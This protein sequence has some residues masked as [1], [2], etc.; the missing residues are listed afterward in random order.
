VTAWTTAPTKVAA[1]TASATLAVRRLLVST[2]RLSAKAGLGT[3]GRSRRAEGWA[4]PC[5]DALAGRPWGSMATDGVASAKPNV[6]QVSVVTVDDQPHFRSAAHDVIDA[7]PGFKAVGEARSGEEALALVNEYEPQL[8]LVDVRMPGMGGIETTRRI[9]ADHPDVVVVLISIEEL[10][11]I[12]S[13]AQTSGAA[14]VVNKRDFRPSLLR[15]L[16]TSHG[17]DPD[18]TATEDD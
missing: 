14:A 5:K 7:T 1:P 11:N 9:L 12:P 3:R 8:V 16:W 17:V 10:A 15:E 13:D 6:D 4:H 18:R 2:P